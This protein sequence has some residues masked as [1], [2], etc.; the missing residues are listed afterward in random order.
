MIV[1]FKTINSPKI[2]R[3]DAQMIKLSKTNKN[4]IYKYKVQHLNYL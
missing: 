2:K 3:N 1:N 4:N